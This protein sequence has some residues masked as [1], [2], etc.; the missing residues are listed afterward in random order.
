MVVKVFS[1]G[2]AGT[3]YFGAMTPVKNQSYIVEEAGDRSL[4]SFYFSRCWP[5]FR[6]NAAL[7]SFP[8]NQIFPLIEKQS[9]LINITIIHKMFDIFSYFRIVSALGCDKMNSLLKN[10][11]GEL[12]MSLMTWEDK[13]AVNVNEVDGQ[14]QEIFRLANVLNDALGEDKAVIAEKL[15]DLVVYVVDH[16]AT[17]EKYMQ[18]TNYPD[19]EA[20][21]KMHDDLVAQVGAVAEKFNAG[22]A[23]LTGDIMAFVRDWLYQHIPNIDKQ[24]GPHLNENGI[25]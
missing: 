17:E 3:V 13:Y 12:Q 21:K 2:G 5:K 14:H 11:K 10:S 9:Y 22:E 25:Q 6:S 19:Y 4:A 23:E 16:F 8:N 15:N 18:E 7:N 24:Y 1:V 20:H